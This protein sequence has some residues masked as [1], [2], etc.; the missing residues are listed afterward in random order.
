MLVAPDS[1][2]TPG[3][4][5]LRLD[6]GAA[7]EAELRAAARSHSA[8]QDA[9]H[10]SR[11]YRAPYA[12]VA[13]HSAAVGA[14]IERVGLTDRRFG[15]SI[16]APEEIG[17]FGRLLDDDAFVT[18]LWSSKEAL[19]K[20]LGDAVAYDPRRLESPLG[21]SNGVSGRWRARELSPAPGHVG[22][23]VWSQSA[24]N[25]SASA[26]SAASTRLRAGRR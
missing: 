10:V 24:Q 15:E 25:S 7:P 14:D 26:E 18:S 23:L 2:V 20:A 8:P 13:W 1:A 11:S 3:Y 6:R 22:W 5:V 9:V 21:W 12:L 16:C 19:A 17:R 4:V